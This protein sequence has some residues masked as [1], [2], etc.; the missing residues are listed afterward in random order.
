MRQLSDKA[1]G[2]LAR[3]LAGRVHKDAPDW[4]GFNE[5]DPGITLVQLFEFLAEQL[6]Y[7]AV[8]PSEKELS[9]LARVSRTLTQLH[10]HDRATPSG[11]TRV[12]YFAGQLLTSDDFQTDQDYHRA[13]VRR[14]TLSL[15]GLGVVSGLHV[16]LGTGSKPGAPI[17]SVSPGSAVAPN[18]EELVICEPQVCKLSA[19]VPR[20]F[21][22][23]RFDEERGSNASRITERVGVEFNEKVPPDAIA[24]A[25]LVRK[26]AKWGV[27]RKFKP[28]KSH[29][30]R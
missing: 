18:G 23:L 11:L 6:L 27:D 26:A 15:V 30:P 25:R 17:V 3:D 5:S 14:L 21:V 20:G 22:T 7:R 29:T 12:H 24:I 13:K 4:T 1:L 8:R 19:S 10:G 28:I 9:T 2:K 16:K